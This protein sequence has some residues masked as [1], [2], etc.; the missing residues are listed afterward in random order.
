MVSLTL[1]AVV[2]VAYVATREPPAPRLQL[3]LLGNGKGEVLVR[4]SSG[5]I[6]VCQ[7]GSCEWD[8]AAGETVTMTATPD[9]ASVFGGY[10]APRRRTWL[11]RLLDELSP[12]AECYSERAWA[13]TGASPRD[14]T[15]CKFTV[16]ARA[17]ATLVVK[18]AKRPTEQ[19]VAI[20]NVDVADVAL[21]REQ[22]RLAQ[23]KQKDKKLLAPPPAL[24]KPPEKK[25]PV[26]ALIVPPPPPPDQAPPPPPPPMPENMR[27]VELPPDNKVEVAPEDATHLSDENRDVKE[28]TR[29]TDTN[30]SRE[31]KGAV[32]ASTPSADTTSPDVGGAEEVIAELATRETI[33][34]RGRET[35]LGETR[36]ESSERAGEEGEN[37]QQGQGSL[38]KGL[39]AMRGISG[40]GSI[41]TTGEAGDGRRRGTPGRRGLRI[42]GLDQYERIVGKEVAEKER[43]VAT[44]K[45]SQKKGRFTQTSEAI[46]SALDNF[47]PEI[48]PGNQTALKTK[49]H[50]FA[51]YVARMHRRIHAVWGFGFLRE[52]DRRP[53][54]DPMNKESLY[55]ELELSINPDGSLEKFGVVRTSGVTAFDVA[56]LHTL[57]ELAPFDVTPRAIRSK[58]NRVHL[59][60]GFARDWRAC[61][62]FN[63]Q[64]YILT[65]VPRGSTVAADT[66][67]ESSAAE[68]VFYGA[69]PD[70]PE[71]HEGH[72]HAG[73]G[74]GVGAGGEGAAA[75]GAATGASKSPQLQKAEAASTAWLAA[76][77]ARD[78]AG[79]VANTATPFA[80]GVQLQATTKAGLE[81]FYNTML[82]ELDPLTNHQLF[83]AS[84]YEKLVST[85][86]RESKVPPDGYV[87]VVETRGARFAV[88]FVPGLSGAYRAA[89]MTQ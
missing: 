61:G 71:S 60:W 53:D 16:P 70:D 72:G 75:P 74:G 21:P 52:L 86:R 46:R 47:T 58:D 12:V 78:V 35:T 20:V 25:I 7:G 56:A 50:P 34:D 66:G 48:K 29:A 85:D 69:I 28:E 9:R 64:T 45:Q 3:Q 32:A 33:T 43:L 37:G 24:V 42:E 80:V 17:S 26:L 83:S 49:A 23:K 68:K 41:T 76:L 84:D 13:S 89:Q 18:F 22:D 39:M 27:M 19:E 5:A 87:L 15:A 54:S 81:A 6:M 55:V 77:R 8:L 31:S 62:T 57:Y 2:G 38:S 82:R 67:R 11:A 65:E 30:L 44:Q 79:L 14:V 73:D 88:L 51:V 1:H 63:T 10:L 59:R 36:G 40:R 4:R